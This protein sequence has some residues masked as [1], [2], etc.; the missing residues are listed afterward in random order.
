MSTEMPEPTRQRNPEDLVVNHAGELVDA[1]AKALRE[2]APVRTLLARVL[3]VHT[4]ERAF[5][6]GAK[7]E[8]L[9][10][11]QLDKLPSSWHA[12]HSIQL[13]ET[14]TDLDHLVTGPGGVF[15][16]N[17]KH[18][19]DASVWVAGGTFLVNGQRQDYVRA[20]RAEGRKVARLLT[21]ACGFK[22]E[23]IP[24]IAV[25]GAANLKVREQPADVVVCARRRIVDWLRSQPE[26]IDAG[27]VEAI[28]SAAHLR[29]TWAGTSR[30]STESL[31]R[32]RRSKE[33]TFTSISPGAE[34]EPT[35]PE[36]RKIVVAYAPDTGLRLF[37][38]P[39]PH[40]AI[41]KSAGF[42]WSNRQQYWYV[43]DSVGRAPDSR[44]VADLVEQLGLRGFDVAVTPISSE[45]QAGPR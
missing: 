27:T 26:V 1:Q 34:P 20:S 16:V 33:G 17:T 28:Y 5:R 45:E 3:G 22:V 43:P 15:S 25:V 35:T 8:R 42:H 6:I 24:V 12:C 19:P 38:D 10:A 37:G 9:V 23:V 29:A 4:D 40:Q 39:R 21:A 31:P 32:E 44:L 36:T 7:G 13:S 2:S 11:D 14:G 18:H 41:V 30:R